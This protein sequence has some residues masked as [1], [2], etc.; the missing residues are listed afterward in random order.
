[1]S[2][3]LSSDGHSG[4]NIQ[5][6]SGLT[7]NVTWDKSVLSGVNG[8]ANS[9]TAAAA[10]V[11]YTSAPDDFKTAITSAVQY[12]EST[13]TNAVTVNLDVG[14]G[15]ASIRWRQA[16]GSNSLAE[17]NWAY[18]SAGSRPRPGP[19]DPSYADVRSAL[20]A[21]GAAG[22]NTLPATGPAG[23]TLEVATGEQIALGLLTNNGALIDGYT[24]YGA[25]IQWS[26]TSAVA[27]GTYDLIG[28]AEHEISEDLGR[29]SDVDAPPY[30]DPLDLFRF[31]SAGLR[32]YTQDAAPQTRH[33][34]RSTMAPRRS[35]SSTPSPMRIRTTG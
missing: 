6:N 32:P 28:T 24:A 1:M 19:S 12:F 15:L 30:Y 4:T 22:A 35:D 17:S 9:G 23:H 13:F 3:R 20:V 25:N 10:S 18:G 27:S 31:S 2:I 14:W 5:F 34:S 33:I 29:R 26:W 16:M 21:L 8:I 7:I 11:T